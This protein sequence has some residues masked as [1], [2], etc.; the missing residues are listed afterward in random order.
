MGGLVRNAAPVLIF[1]LALPFAIYAAQFA[2]RGFGGAVSRFADPDIPWSG[3]S[4][5]LHALTGALITALAVIQ[6]VP[7]LRRRAILV[8]RTLG[9]CVGVSALVTA[10]AGL[11]FIALK[12]TIGGPQMSAGFALYGLLMGLCA[13][14][15]LR[16]ARISQTQRH[17][18]WARRLVILALASWLYRVHYGIW[19]ALT[20]GLYSSPDFTGAFDRVQNWAFYIPYLLVYEF[21]RNR[22][23]P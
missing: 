21:L 8:H 4:I 12:G 19:Y 2:W 3:P 10:C 18:I 13:V 17:G 1:L 9:L 15:V 5:H 14:Q 7:V 16:Y 23:A 20:D 6:L 22:R 11:L